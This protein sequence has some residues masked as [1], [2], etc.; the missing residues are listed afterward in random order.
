ME[1]HY[2]RSDRRTVSGNLFPPILVVVGIGLL[3]LVGWSLGLTGELNDL[4]HCG[5]ITN[6]GARLACYDKLAVPQQPAKGAFGFLQQ[7]P[8]EKP[9]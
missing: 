6:D 4:S 8:R 1:P 2:G 3:V 9:Q 7:E 5:A